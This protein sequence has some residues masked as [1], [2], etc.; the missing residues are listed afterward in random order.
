MNRFG[1]KLHRRHGR[2]H[3]CIRYVTMSEIST[4]IIF[5][6]ATRM[7]LPKGTPANCTLEVK[8]KERFRM[9]VRSSNS[10]GATYLNRARR[11]EEL[12]RGAA[13][14]RERIPEIRRVILFGSLVSGNPTP[15]SDADI[16]VI[17]ETSPYDH[18]RDR[19]PE[20]L[21]AFSPLP[22]PID[23]FVLTSAEFERSQEEKSP[24]LLAAASSGTDL[25]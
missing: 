9:R 18:P 2:A 22:C 15:R 12:R 16:L 1:G 4:N 19:V 21:N 24:L 17:V 10:A 6:L 25:L 5:P 3:D 11:I 8:P 20:I 7:D 14:A 23:L 13:I